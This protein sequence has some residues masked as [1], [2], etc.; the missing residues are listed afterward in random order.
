MTWHDAGV[1][2]K[3]GTLALDRSRPRVA[4]V[5][6]DGTSVGAIRRARTAGMDLAELRIDLFRD[7]G[8]RHVLDEARKF[9]GVPTIGTIRSR[10][11]G[12]DWR[13]SERAR[14][15]LFRA[16]IPYVSAV[17]VELGSTEI[18]AEVATAAH[19][20]DKLVVVSFHDFAATPPYPV[21]VRKL[22]RA[23]RAGADLVKLA[24]YARDD[25]AVARLARVLVN[26]P[27][28]PLVVFAMGEVGTK[29]RVFFPALGSLFTFAPWQ[30]ATAPGQLGLPA[31]LRLLRLFYPSSR[32]VA[33]R[34]AAP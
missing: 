12:G 6:A 21:L 30:R 34:R 28:A 13:R 18:L 5:F 17:D 4:V 19:Q 7:T 11:E 2:L 10:A 24:T 31:T 29:S 20:A 26:H 33:T 22:R 32:R 23:Q 15:A 9:A 8:T 1:M 27:E 25:R 16:V 3:L 14:L